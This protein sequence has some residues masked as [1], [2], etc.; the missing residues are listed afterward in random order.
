MSKIVKVENKNGFVSYEDISL[1]MYFSLNGSGMSGGAIKG[2][3]ALSY[4]FLMDT[5]RKLMGKT[6]TIIDASIL[7]K[8]QNKAIK[9]LIR[10]AFSDEIDFASEMAF[11]QREIQ[12]LIPKDIDVEN[13]PE[14]S[15]EEVLG[16]KN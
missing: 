9:D 3:K 4:S 12:K 8:Q 7:E 2:E 1:D 10:N 5:L 16:V 6:L 14:T 15:I 11:E 13:M